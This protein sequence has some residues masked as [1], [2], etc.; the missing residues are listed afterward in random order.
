MQGLFEAVNC[1]TTAVD[2]LIKASKIKVMSAL[3]PCEQR[4]A[5]LPDMESLEDVDKFR[6]IRSSS[7]QTS[8]APRRSEAGFILPGQYFPAILPWAS[9][10]NVVT[11]KG[12]GLPGSGAFDSALRLRDV[13]STSNQRK[14]T[15]KAKDVRATS[16]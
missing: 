7:S 8:R 16:G 2:M 6:Y 10:R 9:T 15:K 13:T 3:I 12:Q 1:N 5:V 11:F 14:G 4:Q